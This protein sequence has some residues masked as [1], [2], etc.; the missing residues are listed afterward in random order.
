MKR[1]QRAVSEQRYSFQSHW[2]QQ[3]SRARCPRNRQER[4]PSG[5]GNNRQ[6]RRSHKCAVTGAP[7]HTDRIP[8]SDV[9][10]IGIRDK[11]I[12]VTVSVNVTGRD[13]YGSVARRITVC[14]MKG[15]V[16]GAFQNA[17]VLVNEFSKTRSGFPSSLKS[18]IASDF[19]FEPIA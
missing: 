17:D 16:T 18:P 4:S 10:E 11:N 5:T 14:Q 9:V 12:A 6:V 13:E 2:K 3:D 19:G 8:L 15:T 1:F 7:K